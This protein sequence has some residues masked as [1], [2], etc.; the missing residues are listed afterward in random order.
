MTTALLPAP[1]AP[2]PARHSTNVERAPDQNPALVYLAR[3]GP[4][5]RRS[6]RGALNTI[7][8]ILSSGSMDAES[9][10]WHH[11][12][13]QH[14]SAIRARLAEHYAPATANKMISALRGVLKEAWRLGLMD[15]E[16][17]HRAADL[18]AVRGERLPSGR[19]LSAGEIRALFAACAADHGPAG[20]RDAALLAVLYGCGLRRAEAVGLDVEDY[21]AETGELR[22]RAGKGNKDRIVWASSGA[23]AAL[24]TWIMIRGTEVGPLFWP[25]RKGGRHMYQRRMTTHALYLALKRRAEAAGV[26]HFTPHDLRRTFISDLL[27]AGADISTVQQLAGHANVTTTQRYDRRGDAVKAKAVELLHVPYSGA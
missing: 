8:G 13:Y 22:V 26:A 1:T 15:A 20:A 24:D 17:Y 9:L 3:L 5:S 14:S 27:D 10:P 23:R 12:R 18:T 2:V 25:I 19:A 6:M 7:A 11:V 16:D 4:G 21:T